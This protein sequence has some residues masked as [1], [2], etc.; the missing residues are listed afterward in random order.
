[1]GTDARDERTNPIT[2]IVPRGFGGVAP[3]LGGSK[4]TLSLIVDSCFIPKQIA[5]SFESP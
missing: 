3:A 4:G 5:P 2:G 1:M